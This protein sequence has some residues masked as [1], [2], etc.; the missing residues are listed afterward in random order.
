MLAAWYSVDW[1]SGLEWVYYLLLGVVLGLGWALNIL[2]LPGLW[3]MLLG[4]IGYG[5]LTGW[6]YYIGWESVIALFVLCVLAEGVE[7]LA[8]AAGSAQA[9]GSKRGMLGAIGGGLVGGIVGSVLIPVPILGTII[10]AVGGSF[11]GSALVERMIHPD[12]QRAIRI[13][14][15]AA[16]GRFWGIIIKSGFGIVIGV[17]SLITAI[18][19]W[20]G[21]N[22]ETGSSP[23]TI[24]PT[25]T[26]IPNQAQSPVFRQR[27]WDLFESVHVHS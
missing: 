3:L 9:G 21:Y 24:D 19:L 25:P 10:G 17:I 1:Y 7:F 22:S 18:P 20:D 15:G 11:A 13:G 5:L 2:G 16:K 23:P 4:H 6:G 26:T 12:N 27:M 14:I 8:G